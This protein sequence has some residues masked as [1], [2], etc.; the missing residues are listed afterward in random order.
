MSGKIIEES[1]AIN[2]VGLDGYIRVVSNDG[3]SYRMPVQTFVELCASAETIQEAVDAWL[4]E[5]PEAV[6]TV[7]DG[8]I[9]EVKLSAD[10]QET[11]HTLIAAVG[12]PNAAAT[13]EDM[14]DQSKVYVY[15]GSESGY[16]AGNWYYFSNGVWVSGGVYNSTALETDTTLSVAGMAA[17]AKATGDQVAQLKQDLSES[18][19]IIAGVEASATATKNYSIGDM[20]IVGNNLYKVTAAIASGGTITEGTNVTATTVEAELKEVGATAD[21]AH[22][23]YETLAEIYPTPEAPL[24]MWGGGFEN[25][26]LGLTHKKHG[27]V[28]RVSGTYSEATYR[29]YSICMGHIQQIGTGSNLPSANPDYFPITGLQG[30]AQYAL[31][32]RAIRYSY[33]GTTPLYVRMHELA[34]DG[35]TVTQKFSHDLSELGTSG[36]VSVTFTASEGARYCVALYVRKGTM[37]VEIESSIEF[38]PTA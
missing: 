12:G 28:Y 5:H 37:D 35:T 17:D 24:A 32:V 11:L 14:T 20:L 23:L 19:S 25:T 38:T 36:N 9:T 1:L 2:N 18:K 13:V 8:S 10:L 16:T 22:A 15:T 27:N 33:S 31:R 26:V 3:Y 30:D 7:Q 4:E 21:E 29:I 6:T 34:S